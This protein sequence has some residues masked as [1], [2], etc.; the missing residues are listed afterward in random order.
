MPTLP[1]CSYSSQRV[2]VH[3]NLICNFVS[4]LLDIKYLFTS[5][6]SKPISCKIICKPITGMAPSCY[7]K[8]TNVI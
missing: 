5:S 2:E 7:F 4:I 6:Q 3:T 1:F 8:P